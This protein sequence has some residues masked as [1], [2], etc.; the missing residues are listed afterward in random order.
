VAAGTLGHVGLR[1]TATLVAAGLGWKMG[2]YREKIE[3][4]PDLYGRCLG[5]RQTASV[6]VDGRERV[7]LT[8]SMFVDAPSMDRIVLEGD[9]PID[10]K[11]VG[12]VHGDRG[13]I[14]TVVNAIGRV[15]RAP[16]GLVTVADVFV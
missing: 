1:Q 6:D 3:P 16:R 15:E 2:R 4:V 7:S 10:M 14:G 11:I 9:P 5:L 13:T 12:G 8:L